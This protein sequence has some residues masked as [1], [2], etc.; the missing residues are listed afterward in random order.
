[1][2]IPFFA[3][4]RWNPKP[5]PSSRKVVSIPVQFVGSGRGGSESDSSALKIQKVFRGFL[6]RKS[7]K[8]IAAIRREVDEVERQISRE[9]ALESMKKDPKERLRVNETLMSL[10]FRLDSVRGVDSG[11]RDCRKS[12][13]KRAIALQEF[14]D[15]IVADGQTLTPGG[16][17]DEASD[18]SEIGEKEGKVSE[19]EVEISGDN[20]NLSANCDECEKIQVAESTSNLSEPKETLKSAAD[21]VCDCN[22]PAS[23]D[24]LESENHVDC[25]E[26]E[27]I[28]VAEPMSK[29]S[30]PIETLKYGTDL[31]GNCNLPSNCDD[32]DESEK[33]QVAE[34]MRNLSEPN[35][36]LN[37]AVETQS[38]SGSTGNPESL[39]EENSMKKEEEEEEG[40][41]I[42]ETERKEG[43]EK[44]DCC[45]GGR[46]DSKRSRELLEKIMED[47]EKMMGLMIELFQRNE[48]Q[49]KMLSSLSQRVGQLEKAFM[50]DKLRKMKKRG[51]TGTM[52]DGLE[53]SPDKKKS[54]KR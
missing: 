5:T 28:Q 3:S 22:L 24:G 53:K 40:M 45:F 20:C 54:E 4:R 1:M 27:K 29:L 43:N 11:V 8:K 47:N 14:L 15:S 37:Q 18:S 7:V 41:E 48:T 34:S 35:E 51:A 49:T 33:I 39:V 50:C 21:L 52:V 13:I 36:T 26:S 31:V 25:D 38:E 16:E 42:V 9:E 46:E 10:L 2:D 30:E 12:V 32:F 23:C 44:E 17:V 6:V 19:S